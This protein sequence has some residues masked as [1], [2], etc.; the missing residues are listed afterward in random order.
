MAGPAVRKGGNT[1]AFREE[2]PLERQPYGLDERR[3]LAGLCLMTSGSETLWRESALSRLPRGRAL[4]MSL[5][6]SDG[7][8]VAT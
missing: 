7:R 3:H 8:V 4:P 2:L 6:I 5:V 1:E